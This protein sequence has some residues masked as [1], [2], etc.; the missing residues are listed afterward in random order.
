VVG[1][2]AFGCNHKL[3]GARRFMA[4]YDAVVGLLP[5]EFPSARDDN[6]HGT[7]TASTAAGNGRVD[8]SIFGVP[9]GRVS[10]IA[11]R[12]YVAAYKV[13]G[14]EGCY[15][16]DSA[17]AVQQAILDGVDVINFSIS[18][19]ALPF[20]DAVE[21]AFLDAY[22][23]GV[24]VAAS[25]GNAGPGANT[26]DHRGPWVTTVAASTQ[27]RA[28]ANTVT[29]S[30]DG[31]ASLSIEGASV[32]DGVPTPSDVIIPPAANELCITPFAPASLTDK[33]VVCRRGTNGRIN[34]GL[35]ALQGGASGLIL[36][37]ESAAVTDLETDNHFLPTSHVQF[38]DG[39]ALVHILAPVTDDP[40]RW[41]D[42]LPRAEWL[43]A[44][45]LGNGSFRIRS[46][47]VLAD[48]LSF[49]DVV[50][51]VISSDSDPPLV[52]AVR[53]WGGHRTV[54]IRLAEL[55][56][57]DLDQL[58]LDV[59]AGAWVSGPHFAVDVHPE[60]DWESV[61][62]HLDDL[63]AA[64][65]LEWVEASALPIAAARNALR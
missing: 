9:R 54:Q 61:A 1:D 5:D 33:I 49:G 42:V 29:L 65:A 3:I 56:A 36:Y 37:N 39:T 40:S 44:R 13:C 15:A 27:E 8:A 59:S 10:G 18:G 43:W 38:A 20:S 2:D 28:F 35:N 41:H 53:Q 16:S 6:G 63:Q 64:G 23:A 55:D 48:G 46:V 34:K 31:G 4:T 52:E 17:A 47:P 24:F 30:A 50:R 26:T 32:T 60:E 14:I 25:A 11:P 62:A 51:C 22:N 57:F 45:A 21:L 19:G 12:A 7:H 58:P